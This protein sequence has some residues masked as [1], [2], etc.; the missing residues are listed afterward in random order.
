LSALSAL[1]GRLASARRAWFARRAHAV[2]R[3]PVP[4]VSVGNLVVGGSGKTP[5]AAHVA[6][7][8]LDRGERP[9]ILSRGYARREFQDGVVVVSDGT[10]V[11][12]RVER[13]GDEPFMLA[14]ALPEIPVLVCDDRYLAGQLAWRTLGATVAVLDDGFQHLR[15]ARDVNLLLVSPEDLRDAVLPAGRLREPLS[16]AKAADAVLVPIPGAESEAGLGSEAG[17]VAAKAVAA[18]LGVSRAFSVRMTTGELRAAGA[19][20]VPPGHEDRVVAVC[21][22]ARPNRFLATLEHQGWRVA[23]SIVFKDHHWF[24]AADLQRIDQA[25]EAVH[26]TAVLTT[27]KDAVRLKAVTASPRAPWWM[28]PLEASIEPGAVFA[29]WLASCVRSARAAARHTAAGEAR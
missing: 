14:H 26:A 2:R 5:V 18:R 28:V 16:A 27:E 20:T 21:G 6:R 3:L 22:I 7:L 15:L 11:L 23:D 10:S 17:Q 8:L 29:D 13:A 12:E 4:V 9:A 19:D 25:V 1:Y 24:T